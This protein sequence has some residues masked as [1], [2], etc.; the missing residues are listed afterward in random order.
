M[1]ETV[2]PDM[3]SDL[4]DSN[5]VASQTQKV[6]G[7]ENTEIPR[8]GFR[9]YDLDR[10]GVRFAITVSEQMEIQGNGFG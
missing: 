7:T 6:I 1:A 4:R 9:W 5:H 10:H 8:V 3:S 2:S